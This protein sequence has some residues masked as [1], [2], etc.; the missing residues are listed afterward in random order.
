MSNIHVNFATALNFRV[1]INS[2]LIFSVK[3]QKF[4]TH[5]IV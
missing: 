5:K 3:V 1:V 4:D 2:R